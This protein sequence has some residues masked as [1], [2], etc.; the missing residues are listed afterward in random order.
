[1][2]RRLTYANLTSAI[3]RSRLVLIAAF[4]L[5]ASTTTLLLGPPSKAMPPLGS[6]LRPTAA[7][8]EITPTSGATQTDNSSPFT[9]GRYFIVNPLQVDGAAESGT[10]YLHGTAQDEANKANTFTDATNRGTA[11]WSATPPTSS[12]SIIQKTSQRA[13]AD[14]VGNPLSAYWRN[15]YSGAIDGN[16][17]LNLYWSTP[18]AETILL[19]EDVQISVFADPDYVPSRIQPQHLIGRATLDR[20]SQ[21]TR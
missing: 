6:G 7:V 13:A 11:T 15:S 20:P 18:N 16:V 1:M 3:V 4:C 19:G 17:V 9:G 2:F 5:L 21:S 12:N 14:Y 10:L 8:A